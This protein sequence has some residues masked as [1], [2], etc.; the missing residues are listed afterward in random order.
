MRFQDVLA[1]VTSQ[2]Q[3]EHVIASAEQLGQ[4][5]S[6]R[7]ST[8]VVRCKPA[9]VVT[10]DAEKLKAEVERVSARLEPK[11][12]AG[13]VESQLLEIE[14]ARFAIG[15]RAR[16][17]D[18]SVVGRPAAPTSDWQH[19]I[20]EGALFESGRPVL[21]V[22]PGWKKEE[23]GQR[24]FVCWKPAREAARALADAGDFLAAANHV[25]VA[26]ASPRQYEADQAPSR[27]AD[28]V[29]HLG[30]RG[31]DASLLRIDST[32]RNE[33]EALLEEAHAAHA[34]LLVLG[35]YG[36][37]RITEFLFGGVTRDMLARSDIPM[38]MAH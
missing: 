22:P 6:A 3:D 32:H 8:L 18:I 30:R 13:A 23:I 28:I 26:V 25:F 29:S 17:C 11:A 16:H 21:V 10:D 5:W 34:D 9:L 2:A 12:G 36:H 38:L 14:A 35:G 7:I 31:V 27:G 24:V 15:M 19:A 33:A 37:S 1:V 20:L 4:L